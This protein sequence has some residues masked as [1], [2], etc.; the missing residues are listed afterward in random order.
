[1]ISR[2]LPVVIMLLA[3]GVFVV[4]IFAQDEMPAGVDMQSPDAARP[5]AAD[6]V[7]SAAD[8]TAVPGE[9]DD[10]SEQDDVPTHVKQLAAAGALRPS[11]V[12]V[13][14]T[15][16]YDKGEQPVF[17]GNIGGRYAARFIEQERPLEMSGLLLTPTTVLTPDLIIHPRFVEA[18]TVRAGDKTAVAHPK[19]YFVDQPAMLLELDEALPGTSP[20]EFDPSGEEPY[21][22][23][24]YQINDGQWTINV[25]GTMSVVA[26]TETGRTF[27]PSSENIILLTEDSKPVGVS[28]SDE[29]PADDS[30]KGSPLDW[31]M[32]PADEMAEKL[33]K[34]EATAN[35]ALVRVA[36][37]FRSPRKRPG[38]RMSYDASSDSGEERN[39]VGVL[40]GDT[41]V[42]VLA[43]M[44]QHVTRRLERIN[45]YP[46]G[47][48]DPVP[49]KFVASLKDFGGLIAEL[50]SSLPGAVAL[51]DENILD[52]RGKLLML[53]DVKLQ[54]DNRVAYFAHSRIAGYQLGWERI[55]Y[56]V[57]SDSTGVFLF[58]GDDRL[59]VMP[60]SR[61]LK[62]TVAGSY[63][64]PELATARRPGQGNRP[65]QYSSYRSRRK[66]PGLAGRGAPASHPGPSPDVQ[67]LRHH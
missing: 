14:Y 15:L 12:V 31:P 52:Y 24:S 65:E 22:G 27:S 28:M 11:M 5:E 47:G 9:S 53:A 60:I 26:L 38:V 10:D 56:P 50:D 66:P 36:L 41:R 8:D 20:L 67:G 29:M 51:A 58:D 32:I 57:L 40:I 30:W 19:G 4:P 3:T 6:S 25:S 43:D 37:N 39:V 33:Q 48:G 16:R 62:T 61:R 44:R 35:G 54:G 46:A 23:A 64:A 34:V 59:I 42:L 1:M 17:Y 13:E 2:K 45:V 7:P 18:I 55:V 63:S 21:L 49:A